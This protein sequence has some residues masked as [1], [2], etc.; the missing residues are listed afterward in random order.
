MAGYKR[1]KLGE[2]ALIL[3]G[4]PDHRQDLSEHKT[5]MITH[6]MLQP[7]HLGAFN[8]IQGISTITRQTPVDEA[9]L[10]HNHDILLKR[11]NPDNIVLMNNQLQ[12][13]TFSSNL[14][15]VRIKNDFYP[16]Y[17]ACLLEKQGMTWL[18]SN[19]V[20]SV[21]AV[22]SISI[23]ALAELEIPDIN[24][25]KQRS[26]GDMWLLVKRRQQLLT[27]LMT[28]DEKLITAVISSIT[29]TSKEEE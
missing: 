3:N 2:I 20:G 17:I 22:R 1:T 29:S 6:Y 16:A 19:I 11:L 10:I 14:F 24:S 12:N 7:N 27:N 5:N 25:K 13:T 18:N 4:I 21:A 8:N 28:E 26:I 15:V 23:K 9:Y